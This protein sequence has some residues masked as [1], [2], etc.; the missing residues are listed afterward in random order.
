MKKKHFVFFVSAALLSILITS[1]SALATGFMLGGNELRLLGYV[2]QNVNYGLHDNYDTN[3]GLNNLLTTIFAEAQYVANPVSFYVS[4]KL[5]VD[6]AYQYNHNDDDWNDKLFSKSK[7]ALNVDDKYWQLLNEAHITYTPGDFRFRLGKQIVVW[8]QIDAQRL[9][10]QI[11]PVDQRRGFTDVEFET[12]IIPIW[13][14]DAEY[15]APISLGIVQSPGVQFVFN[16]NAD[17]IPD[18]GINTGNDAGGIWAPNIEVQLPFPPFDA[19]LGSNPT[20]LHEPDRWNKEGFEYALKFDAII[21]NSLVTLNGFYGRE[22]SPVELPAGFPSFTT[23]SDGVALMHTPM[24][25]YYARQ[26]FVGFTFGRDITFFRP[27]F[28][29]GVAPILNVEAMYAFDTS[30]ATADPINPTIIKTDEIR[31]ALQLDWKVKIPA[32][33]RTNYI[34]IEPQ[35]IQRR[36]RDYPKAGINT[37]SENNNMVTFLARTYYFNQKLQPF[38]LIVRDLTND[39]NFI[40]CFLQYSPNNTWSYTIGGNFL[41]GD[42]KG[43]GFDVFNNKDHVFFKINYQ[44]G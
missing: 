34:S 9:M 21:F 43:A 27:S 31:Y 33:N 41:N 40:K 35:F 23:A 14:L 29:G 44:W 42:R 10:D 15:H 22:N 37:V 26:K 18:Q 12:S 3:R 30:F 32:L 19:R 7:D 39:A 36:L 25:G 24:E 17:F 20:K 4:G 8:G 1:S 2:T 16:P 28:L 6:W 5:N 11:N 38:F 13:L